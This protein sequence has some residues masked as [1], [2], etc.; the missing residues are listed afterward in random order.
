MFDTPLNSLYTVL[1]ISIMVL[2]VF[3]LIGLHY[4]VIILRDVSKVTETAKKTAWK[5]DKWVIEPTKVINEFR[6]KFALVSEFFE[7]KRKKRRR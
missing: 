4:L 1:S 2:T 7:D 6:K 5:V 3:L